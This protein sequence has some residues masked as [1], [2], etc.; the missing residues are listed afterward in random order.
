MPSRL[1][2]N[3]IRSA[4]TWSAELKTDDMPADDR[5]SVMTLQLADDGKVTG[6]VDSHIGKREIVD[7]KFNSATGELTFHIVENDGKINVTAT[8]KDGKMSGTVTIGGNNIPFEATRT[9]TDASKDEKKKE[10]PVKIEF[11]GIARRAWQLPVKQGNFTGLMVNDKDQLIYGTRPARGSDTEPAIKL[12]DLSADKIEE[13]TVVT[14]A[15]NF[16]YSH[17]RKKLLVLRGDDAFI[18]DA[19]ENQKLDQPLDKKGMDVMVSPREEWKQIFWE[20]WRLERDFFYDPNMQGVD[21]KAVG[22]HYAKMLDDCVSRS[23]LAFLIREMIAELNVGHAYYRPGNEDD[24]P[25]GD[26]GLLG[27]RFEI[28]GDRYKI[29]ELYAGA[30]WDSDARNPLAAAGVKQ[31]QYL[32]QVNGMDLKTSENPYALFQDTVDQTV[33]LTISDDAT[34]DDKDQRLV[35]KPMA[36][37]S[38][39]RFRGWIE[40]NRKY[41]DEKTGGK[42]GYVYVVNTGVPGQNDL[43]RQFYGQLNKDALI[44]DDRWNGGGQ[45]PT[46]FIELLN[47]PVTNFWARRDGRDWPWP[48]D[49]H[50]G[51]KCM[52]TNG[53]A[54]S[55]GDMFPALFR[56]SKLGK[57]IG[58]RTWGGLVGI[59]GSPRLVDG[60]AVTV[61]SFAYYE[62]N[63]TWGI[64][65]YGVEPDIKVV[66]DPAKMTDGGDPQLDSAIEHMLSE[67]ET[68]AFTP[69]KR[70]AYPDR[71]KMGIAPEDK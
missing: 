27:C 5:K 71:S 67:L 14:G 31:G 3:P 60:S 39:L 55:G 38:N 6:I 51:P 16:G 18:I 11:D 19:S 30:D 17:D 36:D 65:G 1:S 37:D 20:A 50:F 46:R 7:G 21:W 23:D 13:K 29:A 42:V 69:P 41:I 61:P 33:N 34:V 24:T 10:E 63:G 32:L 62:L 54:G 70:P 64:E 66:D 22:D 2:Q 12:I 9:D 44:I 43:V 48:P 47:R 28:D 25:K 4:G 26:V 56:Q 58:T 45:I 15:G 52:L 40:R 53:M 8:V 35:I 57:L 59:S 49:A 68:S